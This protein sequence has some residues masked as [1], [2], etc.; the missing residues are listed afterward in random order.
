MVG[1]LLVSGLTYTGSGSQHVQDFAHF[2]G[3]DLVL[4]FRAAQQQV[5]EI[6]V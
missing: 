3:A 6:V 1:F 2:F 4:Q 5:H